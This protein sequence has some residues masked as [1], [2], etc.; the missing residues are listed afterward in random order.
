M[1]EEGT[2]NYVT[3]NGSSEEKDAFV[4]MDAKWLLIRVLVYNPEK[5]ELPHIL[6]FHRRSTGH[7]ILIDGAGQTARVFRFTS[8]E[9][10][11]FYLF[12]EGG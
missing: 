10:V 9:R 11:A 6:S 12:T 4:K 5:E 7:Y 3:F 8:K 2:I 1:L